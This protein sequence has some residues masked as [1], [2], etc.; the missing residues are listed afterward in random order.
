MRKRVGYAAKGTGLPILGQLTTYYR[1]T[2]RPP[3]PLL[4]VHAIPREETE[5]RSSR[6]GDPTGD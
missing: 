6:D 1:V 4:I 5:H 3:L 2:P